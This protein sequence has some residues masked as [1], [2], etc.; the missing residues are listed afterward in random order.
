MPTRVGVFPY[1]VDGKLRREYRPPEEVF[2]AE[3]L[4]TLSAAPVTDLHPALPD[5]SR[6]QVDASNWRQYSVGHVADQVAPDGDGVAT[7]LVIQDSAMVQSVTQGAR[8]EIS[9]GY[10]CDLDF[11]PGVTPSGMK[12]D[13][14]QRRIRY[15][16]VALGPP[17]W[18]R[19]GP[20]S[21]LRLDSG[22]A[23]QATEPIVEK[24]TIDGVEYVVGTPEH[25]AALRKAR[26]TANGRADA[27]DVALKAK[28]VTPKTDAGPEKSTG[29]LD[30]KAIHK[31]AVERAKLLVLCDQVSK[32]KGIK[33][34]A[35]SVPDTATSDKIIA[36]LIGMIDPNFEVSGKTPDYLAGALTMMVR[37]LAG[38][39]A[40]GGGETPTSPADASAAPPVAPVKTDSIFGA[41]MGTTPTVPKTD[42]AQ[43]DSD[44]ARAEML[45]ASRDAWRKP[46]QGLTK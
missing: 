39:A 32:A 18:G 13:A 16:H 28:T 1:V 40:M 19:Q 4:S 9:C 41:R 29:A 2:A 45:A 33:F 46:T 6:I 8:K 30:P 3:S 7:H 15:N 11:T 17:G 22:D 26:D 42:E 38:A 10:L 5:G 34:D 36:D 14:I 23:I 24:E 44:K 21:S 31:V 37:G 12:Y 43:Y 20:E 27:A 35:A 25:L